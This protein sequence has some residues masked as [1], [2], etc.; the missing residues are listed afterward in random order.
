MHYQE[1]EV[2]KEDNIDTNTR[3][4]IPTVVLSFTT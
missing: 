2:H 1:L 3:I 4:Y